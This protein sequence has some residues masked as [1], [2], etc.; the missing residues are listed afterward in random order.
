MFLAKCVVVKESRLLVSLF[1]IFD[2]QP[3][4]SAAFGNAGAAA[5]LKNLN[6]FFY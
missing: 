3:Y 2:I 6:F 5:I 4:T 1:L